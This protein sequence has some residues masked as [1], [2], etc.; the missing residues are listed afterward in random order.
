MVTMKNETFQQEVNSNRSRGLNKTNE[1][2]CAKGTDNENIGWAKEGENLLEELGEKKALCEV[3][4]D[5]R[6]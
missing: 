2:E 1:K 5:G 3:K 4:T 6:S